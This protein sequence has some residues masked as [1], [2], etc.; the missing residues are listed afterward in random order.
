[1]VAGVLTGAH[2][3]EA[4]RAA[5]AGHVLGSV[6]EL[7]ALLDGPAGA[8]PLPGDDPLPGADPHPGAGR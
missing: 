5:G 4:L 7:P 1:V 3:T 8:D 6:A 2:G